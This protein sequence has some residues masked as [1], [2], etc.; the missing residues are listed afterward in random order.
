ML[1]ITI[2]ESAGYAHAVSPKGRV[3]LT[4]AEAKAAVK[5]Y[6]QQGRDVNV[7]TN[8]QREVINVIGGA[9]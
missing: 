6:A 7:K 2:N 4:V 1:T 3:K 9:K 8:D 5:N